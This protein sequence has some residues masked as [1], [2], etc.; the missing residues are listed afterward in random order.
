MSK[1]GGTTAE[2]LGIFNDTN[3]PNIDSIFSKYNRTPGPITTMGVYMNLYNFYKDKHKDT[4]NIGID[5][6]EYMVKLRND[7][8]RL[9]LRKGTLITTISLMNSIIDELK[10]KPDN[11]DLCKKI[12]IL[13]QVIMLEIHS[14]VE[15]L[16]QLE[17]SSVKIDKPKVL[18]ISDLPSKEISEEDTEKLK[19]LMS[20]I[21]ETIKDDDIS[22]DD[23]GTKMKEKYVEMIILFDRLM[24]VGSESKEPIN[25]SPFTISVINDKNSQSQNSQSQNSQSQ[26]S[27]RKRFSSYGK[28]YQMVYLVTEKGS[29]LVY[30]VY[31]VFI[32][33]EV[34][35][36]PENPP[37][38]S[39][40][41]NPSLTSNPIAPSVSFRLNVC[42]S[43]P[44]TGH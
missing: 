26:N 29:Q 8:Y 11:L 32:E 9:E 1:I 24:S 37:E 3:L 43:T 23:T 34:E 35:V 22:V 6:D 33:K 21:H 30:L 16:N 7:E 38:D 17:L 18:N 28:V 41:V 40:D 25:L 5:N 4:H 42:N 13:L 12:F 36:N 14:I 39:S 10:M 20:E 15:K 27:Y 2:D 44:R 19:K 31:L